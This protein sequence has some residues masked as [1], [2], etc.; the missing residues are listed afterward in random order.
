MKSLSRI[1]HHASRI[2]LTIV[3]LLTSQ[4]AIAGEPGQSTLSEEEQK[5]ALAVEALTRLQNVDLDQNPRLKQAVLRTLEKSRGSANFLK[6]V[7][8]FKLSDQGPGLLEVA[9]RNSTNETGVEAARLLLSSKDCGLL[10]KSLDGTNADYGV[11]IS[12]VLANISDKKST[13]LL[14]PVA[15]NARVDPR[16]RRN[17]VR[18][19]TKT[20]EGATALLE[21]ARSDKLPEDVRFTASS[22]LSRVRWPEIK[23]K[24]AKV[25]PL[26]AGQNN[27]QL[28]SIF[29]LV[30]MKGDPVNG[31]KIFNS[32]VVACATCHRV[33]GQGVDFGPDLSEIGTKLGKDALYEAILDP[34]AGISFGYEAFQLQLKSGDEAYGLI[35]SDTADEVAVKAIGGI[36]TRYK[37]S[38]VLK[39]DQMKLS[40][41]PAGLQQNMTPQELVDLVEY[42]ASLKKPK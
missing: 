14:L 7:Q 11:R 29:E 41:M 20:Q 27:Q 17:A 13:E 6:L 5:T 12:E 40:V 23:A 16:I 9:T 31:A 35:V 30:K 19:L 25:L 38:E 24:A 4:R 10:E 33:K 21:L 15:G 22:E 1:T 36:V 3:A 18:G 28:P 34:S 37:K 32:P 42:L 26:P 39:R 2:C 8:Q